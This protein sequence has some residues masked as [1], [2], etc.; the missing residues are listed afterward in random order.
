MSLLVAFLPIILPFLFLVVLKMPAKKGM[1]YSFVI[2]LACSYFIWKVDTIVV[3][4]SILQGFHKAFGIL[5][6][7]FGAI[8]M[9]NILKLNGAIKRINQGFNALTKDMRLQ[10]VVIAYLFGALIEGVAGFGTPA[11]VVAPLLVALNFSPISAATLALISNSVP[12]PFAAVGTPVQVGL[13]NVNTS[14]EFFNQVARYIT[15]IDFLAGVFMPTIVVFTLIF[16][17]GKNKS[18]KDYIEIIPW[19]IFI[20]LSYTLIAFVVARTLG[21]EFIT[22]ATSIVMLGVS[23]I[24]IK[25]KFLIPTRIWINYDDSDFEIS[26]KDEKSMSLLRAWSPYIIV[27]FIL[28]ISRVIKP[29]KDFFLNFIDLS[30]TNILGVEEISSSLKLLY[31]PGFILILVAVLSVYIQRANKDNIKSATIMSLG[32]VKGATLTLLPTLAMVQIFSNSGTNSS[33]LESMPLYLATF[34][35]DNLN[36]IWILLASYVG[37]LGSFITGSATVSALTFSSIQNQI[38]INYG[39]NPE[40]IVSLGLLGGAAGNMICVHNVVSVCAVV[41]TEGKEGLIIKKTVFPALLYALL[42]GLS[43]I[44]LF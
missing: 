9:M 34:L 18:K 11:V 5:I 32:N 35:G 7:L 29:V 22:I 44:I 40:L 23:T 3:F 43:A 41:G 37:E 25:S 31:S 36:S 12:V 30:F 39:L 2:V 28:V 1:L 24:T 8:I 26:N 38:A 4:A 19:T 13:S 14:T 15:S 20:G 27:I 6:I 10:A 42:V 21:F 17:F 33:N 16:F